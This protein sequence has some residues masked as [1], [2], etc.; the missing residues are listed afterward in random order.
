MRLLVIGGTSFVGRHLVE[1]AVAAGHDIAVFHRGRTNPDLLEGRVEHR[2][3]DRDTGDYSSL[4]D[5]EM[6]D[7]VVDVTAYVPRHVRQLADVLDG[8]A[9][10]YVQVS[11]VSAYDI[12]RATI[13]E[14]SPLYPDPPDAA[15]EDGSAAYG[16]LKAACERAA[17]DCFGARSTAIVRPAYICGPYDNEDSFTY[18]ARRMADGGDVVVRDASAP[19]QIIDVR[20]LG[21]FL[22]H[23][24]MTGAAGAFDGVGPYAPTGELLAE[25]TPAGVIARLVEVDAAKLA[26]AAVTLPMMIDDPRDA[27]ISVRPGVEARRA[28]LITRRASETAEATRSWDD[29]RGRPPLKVGPSRAQEAALLASVTGP[30]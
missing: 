9:G 28:G 6:W 18:W 26:A 11:S 7:A 3:G 5:A 30:R 15:I 19:M 21:A 17:V 1:Q 2:L 10:H 12:D 22:L 23:C 25:I 29:A 16:P 8:R 20:D 14:S 27:V 24:A 4:A 13:D